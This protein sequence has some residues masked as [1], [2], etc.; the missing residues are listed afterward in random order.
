VLKPMRQRLVVR[1]SGDAGWAA[2]AQPT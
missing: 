1:S 2:E